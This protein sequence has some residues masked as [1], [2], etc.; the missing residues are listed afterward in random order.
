MQVSELGAVET[1][2]AGAAW[3]GGP[4]KTQYDADPAVRSFNC[5]E[6]IYCISICA[7]VYYVAP[8]DPDLLYTS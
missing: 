8:Y 6:Y 7:Q 2:E 3:F 1:L 5:I 4:W